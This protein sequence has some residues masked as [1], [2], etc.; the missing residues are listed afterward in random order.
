MQREGIS[1][2]VS[3]R[4]DGRQND[5][6]YRLYRVVQRKWVLVKTCGGRAPGLVAKHRFIRQKRQSHDGNRVVLQMP[7]P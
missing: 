3:F 7:L 6:P 2:P 1:G 5:P 4:A